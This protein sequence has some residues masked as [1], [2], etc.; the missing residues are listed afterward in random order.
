VVHRYTQL[1]TELNNNHSA[2]IYA[3]QK[4]HI[5]LYLV[6][7]TSKPQCLNNVQGAICIERSLVQPP[8]PMLSTGYSPD[9][10]HN[11]STCHSYKN[12][13]DGPSANVGGVPVSF[14]ALT[15]VL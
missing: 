15:E 9:H 4:I 10:L 12:Y 5:D 3:E 2:L 6:V 1:P 7:A 14:L 13:D 11:R 8:K